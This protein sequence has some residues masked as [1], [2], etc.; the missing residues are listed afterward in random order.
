MPDW[1]GILGIGSG[2]VL[3]LVARAK[4]PRFFRE[5][6]LKAGDAIV[7]V[8]PEAEFAPAESLL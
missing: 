7:T 6:R 2:I 3:L 8:T 4:S 1:I 5:P